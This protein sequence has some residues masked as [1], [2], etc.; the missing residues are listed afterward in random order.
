[1]NRRRLKRFM[2]KT[3]DEQRQLASADLGS[4]RLKL[5]RGPY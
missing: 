1:M 4:L 2:L 3:N 5:F